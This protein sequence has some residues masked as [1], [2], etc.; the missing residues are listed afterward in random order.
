MREY[1]EP[2][3]AQRADPYVTN[4]HGGKYYF[5]ASVPEYD[6]IVL[7]EADTLDGLKEA[8]EKTI[9][10][11]HEKGEMSFH[12]WA[13]ELHYLFGGWY[14]YFAASDVDD[15]WK[16]RPYVLKCMGS[17]PM[18]DAWVE[19]GKMKRTAD[20]K[21]SFEAFSLD[22]T[23][24]CVNNEWY[25]VWA[26]KVG[27]GEQISN[28]YIAKMENANTLSTAQVLLS[29]PDY[30]WERHG[31]WVNEGPAVVTHEDKIYLTYSASDTSPAYCVGLLEANIN[32]NLLDPHNWE[33]KRT[34]LL[35]SNPERKLYGPGHNSFTKNEKNEDI[36]VFH[37]RIT[38]KLLCDN[39]LYDP[40]RHAM[41][42][43]VEW[44]DKGMDIIY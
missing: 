5:T 22:A 41:L 40:N 13:P 26:E 30:K 37:A 39:P 4:E 35:K 34:P 10:K 18:N 23:V 15:I 36:I 31:F 6:R 16:L 20:D 1:V 8:E 42:G 29:T 12:V 33:K 9:W 11:K 38:D 25:Y 19:L 28:L 27:A 44:T 7:R 21:F 32:D 43:K 14:L 24:F 17:D 3:I 2:W